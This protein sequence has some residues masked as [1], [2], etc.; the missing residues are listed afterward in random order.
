MPRKKISCF[1][2]NEYIYFTGEFESFTCER[3]VLERYDVVR[4]KYEEIFGLNKQCSYVVCS[5]NKKLYAFPTSINTYKIL[6]SD[7][8]QFAPSSIG[9]NL[10][11]SKNSSPTKEGTL[12]PKW[13]KITPKNPKNFNLF[14]CAGRSQAAQIS[15]YEILITSLKGSYIF[16]TETN[17]FTY[18]NN[19]AV[20]DEFLDGF[21]ATSSDGNGKVYA[22]G[23]RSLQVYDVVIKRWNV[24]DEQKVTIV[25]ENA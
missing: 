3:A 25:E 15:K 8:A 5:F 9:G 21:E 7:M 1:F 19:Y 16:N 24:I 12:K 18:S 14:L 4:D 20:D 10:I 23:K 13:E 11:K 6:V 22:Y 17:E 2:H